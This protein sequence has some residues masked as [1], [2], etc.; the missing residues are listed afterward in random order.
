[1]F[2]SKLA[3]TVGWRGPIYLYAW[4]GFTAF[5]LKYLAPSFGVMT[6]H[7]SKLE[8]LFRSSHSKIVHHSEEI[9]FYGGHEWEC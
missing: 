3:G 9:A 2:S 8:G 4:Y 6:R 5:L 7:K 1:M